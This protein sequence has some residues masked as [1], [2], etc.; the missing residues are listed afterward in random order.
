MMRVFYLGIF[1][2]YDIRGLYDKE[3]P[4][5]ICYEIGL[6]YAEYIGEKKTFSVAR[7]VRLSSPLLEYMLKAGILASGCTVLTLGVQPTPILYF[8]VAHLGFDGGCMITASHNPPEYNGIKLCREKGFSL[9][10]EDGI[11]EIENQVKG[12][13]GRSKSWDLLGEDRILDIRPAYEACLKDRISF[14]RKMRI[15]IDA[16]NGTCGFVGDMLKRL[17]CRVEVLFKEPDGRFPNHIP[18]PLIEGTLT[19]LKKRVVEFGADLGIAFDGDGDRVGFV[20]EKGVAVKS[21]KVI[22][23]F[24]QDIIG[25][26]GASKILFDVATS[27]AV[28]E[29]VI[30]LGGS[31]VMTRVGHSY[32]MEALHN[33]RGKM[34]GELSGH[35]YFADDYYGFDD[36]IYAAMRMIAILSRSGSTMSQ[37]IQQLPSYVSTPEER[38]SCSDQRKFKVVEKVRER[39]QTAGYKVVTID[40]VRLELDEGWALVRASNTEPAIVLRFEGRTEEQLRKIKSMVMKIVDGIMTEDHKV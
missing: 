17:H 3:L 36:G 33:E 9:T 21:D 30:T 24:A 8:S 25:R 14:G 2:A 32:V 20:D 19:T 10:Y 28:P 16:G 31:P 40:G 35:Y 13:T 15:V 5:Q 26:N 23:I 11:R 4:P 37:T 29:Y 18:N 27:K 1:R 38:V 6:A 34:A 7:D 12:K 22:M 39:L